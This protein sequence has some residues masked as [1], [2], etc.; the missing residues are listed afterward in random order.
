MNSMPKP[1]THA[2]SLLDICL[3][4]NFSPTD[5]VIVTKNQNTTLQSI[6][7]N[8]EFDQDDD[9][10]HSIL[11][12]EGDPSGDGQDWQPGTEGVEIIVTFPRDA[13]DP[14]E[15]RQDDLKENNQITSVHQEWTGAHSVSLPNEVEMVDFKTKVLTTRPSFLRKVENSKEFCDMNL[16]FSLPKPCLEPKISKFVSREDVPHFLKGK[17]RK[18][19]ELSISNMKCNSRR[20]EFPLPP[21]SLLPMR[22]GLL[23]IPPNHK[24]QKERERNIRS[25]ASFATKISEP[26]SQ[27]D[28]FRPSNKQQEI[29]SKVFMDQTLRPSDS[30]IWSRNMCSFWK[31]SH[32]RKHLEVEDTQNTKETEGSDKIKISH[33]EKCQTLVSLENIEEDKFLTERE[34]DVECHSSEMRKS[35]DASS[36]NLLLRKKDN[37]TS[38]KY[39][40][41]SESLCKT[42]LKFHEVQHSET[43][44]RQD[45]DIRNDDTD[46]KGTLTHKGEI[47]ESHQILEELTVLKCLSEVVSDSPIDKLPGG[48]RGKETHI[49]MSVAE[50]TKPEMNEMVP[51][52]HI[53]F[54]GARTPKEPAITKPT[55]QKRKGA[56]HNNSFNILSHPEND[57]HKMKIHRNKLDSKAK[58]S[59]RTPQGFMISTEGSIKPPMHKTSIKPQVFPA[60]GLRQSPKFQR[61]M[62][63]TEK[64]Q[65]TY[66]TLKPKK[67]SFPCICK[68]PGIKKA[69]VS[70]SVQPME[71]KLHYLD[72]KYSD[73]FKEINSTADGPGIYEMFGTPVYCHMRETER[74]E[75]RYYQEI[76]SAPSSRC[77]TN[78]CCSSH[79][80]RNSSSRARHS[81]KRPHVKPPKMSLGIKKKHK[82]STSEEK[83]CKG[84]GRDLHSPE[85]DG[86]ISVPEWQI[87]SSGN[88]FISSRDED[89]LMN[90]AQTHKQSTEQKEFHPV[91]DL[92][93]I[94][95]VPMEESSC[96]RDIFNNQILATSLRDL[97][98]LEELH[99]QTPFVL[100]EKNWAVPSEKCSNKNILQEEQKT[101]SLGQ[102]N[103]NQFLTN[104][105]E[106]DSVSDKSETLMNFSFAERQE[107]ASSQTYQHWTH[108]WDDDSLVSNS[109]TTQSFGQIL[110]GANSVSQ[111]ILDSVKKEELTDELLGCLA[112]ELLALD[113]KD[114]NLCQI[115]ANETD[116]ENINLLFSRKE[117][118]RQDLVRETTEVEI[119]KHSNG[120]RIYDEEEQFLKSDEKKTFS[121]HSLKYEEPI[122]WTKGEILGK[123]AYGTETQGK[124]IWEKERSLF[125][126][127]GRHSFGDQHERPS[128]VQLLKHT[129]MKRSH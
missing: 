60:L 22:S 127:T 42:L 72:L 94:E 61:R 8:E 112:A 82:S 116:P 38:K 29:P 87:K 13:T 108:S 114:N 93:I 68:N 73:M 21:L 101:A 109:I 104:N 25:L 92:S 14:L 71:P 45:K 63:Q 106:F 2:E 77:I 84:V 1:E 83:G 120:V 35:G 76:C 37:F 123:G 50:T 124:L 39:E 57:R 119:Q 78:K 58:S 41:D 85:N 125:Y 75:N 96:E 48:H 67:Q 54:P 86:L 81:Q 110:N 121:E 17:Q 27:S 16:G 102:I 70:L 99:H 11:P 91:S 30:S 4:A 20:I 31:A 79:S 5:M 32:Y 129:F 33:F 6:S 64:K 117:N 56:L 36:Q 100:S 65:S 12:I 95:E 105:L 107:S 98:E 115:M 52:V 74:H 97:H 69:S 111:E 40:Q 9:S 15:M 118:A 19:E 44:S 89:Q 7:S 10:S 55:L 49:K 103:T 26:L 47:V 43:T 128:A 23:T 90:L 122:L 24:D 28:E 80:E 46:S 88:D 18:S 62:P 66:R 51:L 34:V 126:V 59:N 113:E 53:T 3:E